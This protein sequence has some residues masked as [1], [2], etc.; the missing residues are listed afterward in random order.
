MTAG[1]RLNSASRQRRTPVVEID[2]DASV[3]NPTLPTTHG[4]RHD[5]HKGPS[6][7]PEGPA[8]DAATDLLL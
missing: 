6:G 1:P 5:R 4:D 8:D 7:F 2:A 3:M